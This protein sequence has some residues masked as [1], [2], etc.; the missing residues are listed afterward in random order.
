MRLEAKKTLKLDLAD[1]PTPCTFKLR[2]GIMAN[3][4]QA[5]ILLLLKDFK[6][7]SQ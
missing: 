5:Q 6:I 2:Q 3:I 4:N 1:I 7:A